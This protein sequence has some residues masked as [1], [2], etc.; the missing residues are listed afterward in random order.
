MQIIEPALKHGDESRCPD[1]GWRYEPR[2][3]P[4]GVVDRRPGLPVLYLGSSGPIPRPYCGL[5]PAAV[6]TRCEVPAQFAQVEELI[7]AS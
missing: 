2:P 7:Y 1:P 6:M 5:M 3:L 4:P